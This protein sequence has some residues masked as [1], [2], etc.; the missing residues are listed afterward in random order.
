MPLIAEAEIP[1]N[2]DDRFTFF[3]D[4]TRKFESAFPEF[5]VTA[6]D[7]KIQFTWREEFTLPGGSIETRL[8]RNSATLPVH[9]VKFLIDMSKRIK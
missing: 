2:N 4:L 6:F 3:Y 5:I 8:S 9:I 7:P 1:E